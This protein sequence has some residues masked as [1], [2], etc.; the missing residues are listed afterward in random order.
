MLLM[1]IIKFETDSYQYYRFFILAEIDTKR[2]T[3]NTIVILLIGIN[4]AA[5][6]GDKR[7]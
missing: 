2:V 3:N 4:I 7:L 6:I 1:M 5:I